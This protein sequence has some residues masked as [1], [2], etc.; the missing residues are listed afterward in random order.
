[1]PYF[2]PRIARCFL[3]NKG[4]EHTGTKRVSFPQYEQS[5]TSHM[6]EPRIIHVMP[7]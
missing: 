4:A 3:L 7:T 1:M 2:I 5:F 6:C